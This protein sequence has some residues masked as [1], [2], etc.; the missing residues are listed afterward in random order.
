MSGDAETDVNLR[1]ALWIFCERGQ[2]G[3]CAHNRAYQPR[4]ENVIVHASRDFY[5][6][7]SGLLYAS[8]ASRSAALSINYFVTPT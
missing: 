8:D 6:R 5:A 2:R 4:N 3:K 1:V 7:E